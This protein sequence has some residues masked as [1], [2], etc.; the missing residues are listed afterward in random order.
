MLELLLPKFEAVVFTRYQKNPRAVPVSQL[1][2]LASSQDRALRTQFERIA[3][4]Q[5]D[6]DMVRIRLTKAY[7]WTHLIPC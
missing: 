3:Q 4:L 2:Q 7:R 5:A 6:C 1:E